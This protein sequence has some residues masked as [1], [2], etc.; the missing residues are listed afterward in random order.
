MKPTLTTILIGLSLCLSAAAQT[1]TMPTTADLQKRCQA[2]DRIN[3]ARATKDFSHTD[4]ADLRDAYFCG[5]YI[6]GWMEA[7][8]GSLVV[9][10]D[11]PTDATLYEV[12]ITQALSLEQARLFFLRYVAAHPEV[13][14]KAAG[15]TLT[16]AVGQAGFMAK[17]VWAPKK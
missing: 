2:G 9:V 13:L 17:K 4:D 12:V 14:L 11:T 1:L 5:G 10:Y 3:T 7:T 15:V 16:V 8:D 6:A